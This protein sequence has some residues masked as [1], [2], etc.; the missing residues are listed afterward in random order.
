MN[1]RVSC[2]V[3]RRMM[4]AVPLAWLFGLLL[5]LG[6]Q[7]DVYDAFTWNFQQVVLLL[8]KSAAAGVVFFLAIMLLFWWCDQPHLEKASWGIL[9]RIVQ[10]ERLLFFLCWAVFF[11]SFLPALLA[12]WPGI[13]AY[14]F[15]TQINQACNRQM[16]DHHP[17]LHTLICYTFLN[18]GKQGNDCTTGALCYSVFQMLC[19]SGAFAYSIVF[20]VKKRVPCHWVL[21]TAGFFLLLPIHPLF[22]INATKD[23]LFTAA[24]MLLF[25][26]TIDLFE[27]PDQFFHTPWRWLRYEAS[28]LLMCLLRNTGIYVM[29]VFFLCAVVL[30]KKYR[31]GLAITGAACILLCLIAAQALAAATDA[32]PGNKVEMVA[33]PI[34]QVARS[35]HDHKDRFTQEEL[36]TLYELIPEEHLDQ[37]TS[38]LADSVKNGIG[39]NLRGALSFAQLWLKKMPV[40]L[41][42]YLDSFL[43]MTEGFWYPW[44]DYPDSRIYHTYIE[45]NIK[46][47]MDNY[48][49]TRTSQSVAAYRFYETIASGSG[50]E[51]WPV[52]SLLFHP[53]TYAWL[54]FLA[55]GTAIYKKQTKLREPLLLLFLSWGVL[56]L[57]PI[58]LLRYAYPL[59]VTVPIMAGF[60]FLPTCAEKAGYENG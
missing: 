28:A 7:I 21:I 13:F 1:R 19:L 38:R 40:C 5:V 29:L 4:I 51:Q 56:L 3:E 37:Y 60:V 34:Q 32:V 25:L 49:I 36:E 10:K 44:M 48:V 8:G 24:F 58:A 35:Y 50:A 54:L 47:I 11:I 42:S 55:I 20:M 30:C 26:F 52:V 59:V 16:T 23:V 17:I 14:D 31:I 9:D 53:G 27:D 15:T 6:R 2:R 33:L 41:D 43:G 12:Y 18:I 22:A 45:T 46:D 39:W 57:S